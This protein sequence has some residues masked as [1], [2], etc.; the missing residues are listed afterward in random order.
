MATQDHE[1]A[2]ALKAAGAATVTWQLNR[3]GVW[4]CWMKGPMPLSG[5]P[6]A[7]GPAFTLAF[8]PAREDLATAESYRVEGALRDSLEAVPEGAMV[9]CDGR[10]STACGII[11]DMYGTRLH[12][13]GAAGFVSDTPVRDGEGVALTGLP[14]WCTGVSAPASIHDLHFTGHGLTIGCG[15]VCVVPGDFLVADGDGVV[16]VPRDIAAEV[17]EAAVVQAEREP[18]I[19]E[20]LKEGRVLQG[21]YPPGEEIQAEYEAWRKG[22]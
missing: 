22:R 9:V 2:D 13:R 3:R 1:I 14:V 6:R 12:K 17:A 18:F 15:G 5:H 19:L 21:L 20:K 10:G 11:G 16:V 8:V 7:A 4:R